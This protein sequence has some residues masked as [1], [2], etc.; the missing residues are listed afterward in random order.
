MSAAKIPTI[1]PNLPEEMPRVGNGFTKG[2]GLLIVKMLGWRLEGEFPPEKKVMVALAPHTSNWDFV[3]A[4]P[5]IMAL[6]LKAS[7][8][9]KKEAFFFPFKNLFKALGGIPT[10]R[11]AAG[12]MAKQVASQFRK[13]EKMWVAITPEGTRKKTA[14]WKNGFLRIAYAADVPVLLVAWDFPNKRIFVDSLYR[15]TGDLEIDMR[16]IQR[17]FHKYQG[18]NPQNQTDFDETV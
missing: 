10:D 17:R 14:K 12:G 16:E 1:P 4:M 15:P 13:N 9:M 18:A 2:I 3:V 5:F 11:S 6:R 7:W 8:L